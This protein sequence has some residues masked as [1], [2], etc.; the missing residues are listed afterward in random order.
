MFENAL[1]Y[2]KEKAIDLL[3]GFVPKTYSMTEEC[4][5]L[6][7]YDDTFIITKQENLVAIMSL[8]GLS[9]S[10]LMQKDL[11]GYF[12][13]R[14][15][16]L[17]TINKDIQL[18]IVA[19]RRKEFINQ[20]P[21]IDNIYAKA[22]ITQFESKEI[23]KTEYFLVFES[24]TSNV[25]SF[26]EK[27]KLEMTTSINEELEESS[28]ENKQENENSSNETHSN[29]SSN[30]DKKNKFKKKTTFSATSKRALLIQTIERVKNALREFRPTLLNSKEVLNFYAEYINGKYIAFNPKLKRLSDSYI[31]SNIH[32]K[33]DYFIIEFQNQSTFCACVGIKNYE[34]E[35]ISSLPISTLLHTQI[36]LDLIFHIR[37]L[38]QFESLNFLKT[39][40]KLTL[41]KIVKNDIDDYIELVQANRLSMQE[42]ALNLVL[43]A[44]SK[45][46]LDKSLKE[47]LS[48]LNN[49][50][51]GSVTE[52]I[53]LKPSYFSF[54]PNNANINPRMRNQ[55]SQV[56]ASLILFEK[57]NTGFRANSWGDMP[58]SVFKNLDHSPYLFNFHN[59]EVKHKGVLAHNVARVVGHTMII[60]ATGAGKTTLISYLMMSTLKYPNIDILALDRLNGLYSFTKYFDGIYNE[61]ES[62]H[63]NPFSLEDSA[64]NRA[65][66]LHFYAQ[67]AKVDS[68]DKHNDKIEDRTALL[69]AIDTMYRNYN[70]EVKQAKFSNQELPLPFDLKEFVNSIV[71]TN[72]NILDSSFEHYLKSSLFSSRMDS[73]DFKTRIST[74]NTDSILHNDDDAGLLAYYV[75]H[76]M[77]DRALKINRGFLCFVDEFKSY[78]QNEMMNKEINKIITQAR[79][80]NG[81]IVLA[82]QDINQLSEVKNAQS[83]IKNMGQLILYPQRN[84]D[85]KDLND[86]FGIRLSD[87]EKHFL[88]NTAVNEYKVLLKNM[89][90]GSSNIIDVSLSS[91]G[92]YLQIF[93][94][95]SSMVEHIENLIK[96]YPTTWKEVF[97]NNTYQKFDDKKHLEK[98]LCPT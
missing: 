20:S 14:Q 57:N 89:N 84:I 69:N 67:M 2:C 46:K 52:T 61:G 97:V 77:I 9:Y 22:I 6:G 31:A 92:N 27:K 66:L 37:S 11:E 39:K 44:K 58:L 8:Q 48:L 32:F 38:G 87:T 42:C 95:N 63:I 94:S 64:S 45:A 96:H 4:N 41:S 59:Q 25:K 5:I 90:D 29:T 21:N 15:N 74:I 28:K 75:F 26:F 60:G 13:T 86:K 85:T 19:K 34:S 10:N 16:V 30:K 55:T 49:A 93:S 1:K 79:K 12:D 24:I 36:E 56:I 53:G 83:F 7:L 91:L 54:F 80:A 71:K 18:R 23:Y 40:K 72:T 62:F 51:L 82:L 78:A 76:K 65:F 35:E 70:D 68:Y 50:G 33:K 17:N 98:V 73:L 88:E 81:V 3:T 43:R 47:I